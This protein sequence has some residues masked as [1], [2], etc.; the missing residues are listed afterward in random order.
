M[1]RE[2]LKRCAVPL[3]LILSVALLFSGAPAGGAFEW[4]D[5]P[6]HALNGIFVKDL[7]LNGLQGPTEYAYQ[8]Y[9]QYPALTIL[10]Y[11][12]LFYFISA[13]FY[14]VFGASHETAL[15]VVALHYVAFVLGS[16]QLFRFWLPSCQAG[17]AA[18]MLALSPEIASWGRQV[19]LEI[20]AF[21]FMVWSAVFFMRYRR[22]E[23]AVFLYVAAALLALA[24]YTKITACFLV[25]VFAGTLIA[26][27]RKAMLHDRQIW[28]VSLLFIVSLIPLLVLTLKFGQ[29]N[30]Q[31]VTGIADAAASRKTIAGWLWYLR[32]MP[33]Q[34][35]WPLLITAALAL[36]AALSRRTLAGMS[37]A[38]ALFWFLWFAS[39]YLFF[40]AIDLKEARHSIYILPPVVLAAAS[41][42]AQLKRPALAGVA[43]AGLV[44]A[45]AVQTIMFRPVLYVQGYA[46]AAE[47]VAQHAPRNSKVLFSGYR[48]GSFVFNMRAREDRRDMSVVRADKMLL[49]VAVRRELGVGQKNLTEKEMAEQINGL[50]VHYL[51]VQPGFWNDLEVMQRF[52]R[53]L[54]SGQFIEVARVATPANFN[55]HEKELVIYKNTGPVSQSAAPLELDLPIIGHKI[56]AVR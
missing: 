23:R 26:E 7:F 49:K 31:S 13:P 35:G 37:R 34:L 6:R 2:Y 32:Q 48:D 14:A 55:A 41:L 3:F 21:A 56:K 19:M 36:I 22:E 53:M 46:Q 38:D 17:A 25:I 28:I 18:L 20:P 39:G 30:V 8:Y 52:E 44:I 33:G 11:P 9:A 16:W 42:L 45:I 54:T 47:F 51:V 29:A 1:V 4:S 5:S 50:G 24:M 12:P 15:L 10:F 40:S 27:R 43:L